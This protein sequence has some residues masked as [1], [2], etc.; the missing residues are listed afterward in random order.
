MLLATTV[1]AVVVFPLV[2]VLPGVG[3]IGAALAA[4][5]FFLMAGLPS[6]WTGPN[7]KR[8]GPGGDRNRVPPAGG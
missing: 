7:S 5:G 2:A 8:S 4:L 1:L 3:L 6:P